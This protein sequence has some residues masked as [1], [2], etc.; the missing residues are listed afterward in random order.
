MWIHL[1]IYY[2]AKVRHVYFSSCELSF[3]QLITIVYINSFLYNFNMWRQ[4][5][6]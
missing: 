2:D 1:C 4:A 3:E 6:I 5:S